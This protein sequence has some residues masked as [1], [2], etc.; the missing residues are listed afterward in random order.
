MAGEL[1]ARTISSETPDEDD[2][3]SL[4]AALGASARGRAFLD[5]HARRNRN[6]DT[7]RVLGALD[8][9]AAQMRAGAAGISELRIEMRALRTALHARPSI[10][11]NQP[12]GKV[13]ML[14]GLVDLLERRI[15][16]VVDQKI[17]AEAPID[18]QVL[19]ARPA[20]NVVPPPDEPELPIPSPFVA[21]P[22]AIAIVPVT[23]RAPPS[24]A[25][26]PEVNVFDG[27]PAAVAKP[28]SRPLPKAPALPGNNL[29]PPKAAS[30]P[31]DPVRLLAPIMALSEDERLAL[32]T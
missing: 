1:Q 25:V 15:D 20:L 4:C 28:M 31:A 3:R 26:M 11:A 12:P 5:E 6:A 32:F 7:K 18:E 27:A 13:A 29:A 30:P 24:T 10:E 21:Q 14:T 8:R 9:L 23:V 17:A 2:Y 22:P 16:A 19:P